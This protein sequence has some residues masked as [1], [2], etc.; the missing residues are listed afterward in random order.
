MFNGMKPMTSRSVF[1][2]AGILMAVAVP[3]LQA[4]SQENPYE[5]II[6]RNPFGL[7]P[8]P[9]PP[10][11]TP[12]E[13][14]TPPGKV[15]LTGITSMF[16]P[17]PRAC[18]EITEQEPGKAAATRKPILREGERDGAV[19]V[20]SIDVEKS[21]V[22]IRNAGTETDLVF[23]TPKLSANAAPAVPPGAPAPGFPPSPLTT[24][25]P[26]ALFPGTASTNN[27]GRGSGVTV[28]GA[29]TPAS[30]TGVGGVTP[31]APAPNAYPQPPQNP[32]DKSGLRT[33]PSRSVRA[34]NGQKPY[35]ATP[36][37][38]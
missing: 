2:L 25:V 16:G 32:Y 8:P 14:P 33:I 13:K 24:A 12:T 29:S 21:M 23:E 27:A 7:K 38:R 11:N 9:P 22:K 4:E 35:A 18:L 31:A 36:L 5:V 1:I 19:E 3:S 10:D 15:I 28:Y 37:P 30:P 20:V 6:E 34:D 17:T 26:N